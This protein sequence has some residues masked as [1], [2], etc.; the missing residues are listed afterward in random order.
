M[1]KEGGKWK[2]TD[3]CIQCRGILSF[4][5]DFFKHWKSIWLTCLGP[6]VVEVVV[7]LLEKS[8]W[9][10]STASAFQP[11]IL[12]YRPS[13]Q[14]IPCPLGLLGKFKCTP[15]P[16]ELQGHWRN[17]TL[18]LK[19]EKRTHVRQ[20]GNVWYIKPKKETCGFIRSRVVIDT[21]L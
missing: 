8:S 4:P 15:R 10:E 14:C 1:Y 19:G 9:T 18:K 21:C 5:V 7:I 17:Q 16:C 12:S 13:H 3:K 20:M 6:E 2:E 11:E